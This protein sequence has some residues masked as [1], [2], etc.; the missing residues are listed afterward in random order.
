MQ[1]GVRYG[2]CF[3]AVIPLHAEDKPTITSTRLSLTYK[4]RRRRLNRGRRRSRGR[5]KTGKKGETT[6]R[7]KRKKKRESVNIRREENRERKENLRE[8]E[9]EG[10]E[11]SI[12]ECRR[13]KKKIQKTKPKQHP[14]CTTARPP[15]RRHQ[16]HR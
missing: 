2:A 10:S 15:F 9:R 16:R 1:H 7:K 3:K 5:K 12:R 13:K 8:K 11:R 6:E 14:S 4:S